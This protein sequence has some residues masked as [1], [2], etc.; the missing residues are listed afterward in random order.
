MNH[1]LNGQFEFSAP[2]TWISKA[3]PT[4]FHALGSS[5]RRQSTL[6]LLVMTFDDAPHHF[7]LPAP[8]IRPPANVVIVHWYLRRSP[9]LDW[10]TK[11]TRWTNLIVSAPPA[12][13]P[14][15]HNT[16][17]IFLP[18]PSVIQ[19]FWGQRGAESSVRARG[20]VP[21][22]NLTKKSCSRSG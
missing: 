10:V 20:N 12:V 7:T 4:A 17:N 3:G 15:Q 2:P 14:F 19:I 18:K 22:Q 13:Y 6:L 11:N 9:E 1:G 8:P 5:F 21:I 16:F